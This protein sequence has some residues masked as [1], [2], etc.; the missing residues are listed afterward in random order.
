[1]PSQFRKSSARNA[2]RSKRDELKNG[3]FI[4][5]DVTYILGSKPEKKKKKKKKN[6]QRY[7]KKFRRQKREQKAK[8]GERA[9]AGV[10]GSPEQSADKDSS[11]SSSLGILKLRYKPG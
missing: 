3:V 9:S 4:Q 10:L 1:M 11:A 7:M 5:N 2:I 8:K 6:K